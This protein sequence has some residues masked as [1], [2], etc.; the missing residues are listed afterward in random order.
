MVSHGNEYRAPDDKDQAEK[1]DMRKLMR[2]LQDE[3][4]KQLEG[5]PAPEAPHPVSK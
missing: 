5:S 2:S 4:L 3:D 1:V